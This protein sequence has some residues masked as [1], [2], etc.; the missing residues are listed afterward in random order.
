MVTGR[1]RDLSETAIDRTP[2]FLPELEIAEFKQAPNDLLHPWCNWLWQ[3]SRLDRS[4]NYDE[5]GKWIEP[6]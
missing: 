5:D 6:R 4:Y 3:A 1:F 2:A